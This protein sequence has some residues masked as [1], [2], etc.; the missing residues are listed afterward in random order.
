MTE[1]RLNLVNK[2]IRFGSSVRLK[3]EGEI[4]TEVLS[5]ISLKDKQW[6]RRFYKILKKR[7]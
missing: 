4:A 2:H 7:V 6:I 3:L 1:V 5:F